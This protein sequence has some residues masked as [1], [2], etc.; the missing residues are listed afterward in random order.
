MNPAARS[1]CVITLVASA[2]GWARADATA[3]AGLAGLQAVQ[4]D[5]VG[6]SASAQSLNLLERLGD[7]RVCLPAIEPRLQL[8]AAWRTAG[9]EGGSAP[10]PNPFARR[11]VG[12]ADGVSTWAAGRVQHARPAGADPGSDYRLSTPG[13][14]IGMDGAV[15]TG[16]RLGVAMSRG[17]ERDA[18]G[19]DRVRTSSNGLAAY[20]SWPGSGSLR[21]GAAVGQGRA[22]A[23][24]LRGV[25]EGVAT[26]GKRR[27]RQ[28]FVAVSASARWASGRWQLAPQLAAEHRRI[29]FGG[30]AEAG[31]PQRAWSFDEAQL[32]T[33]E[34]RGAL[35]MTSEWS[36]PGCTLA[37]ALQLDWRKRSR[38]EMAQS[39]HAPDEVPADAELLTRSEPAQEETRFGL[40]LI[41]RMATGWRA[42]FE[43]RNTLGGTAPRSMQVAA[44][45]RRSF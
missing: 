11:G 15:G 19:N 14:S 7:E 25:G 1:L 32:E 3:D 42:S 39:L 4:A 9:A 31:D 8:A 34:L 20:A 26:Q 28:N 12:C 5:A 23:R 17:D 16:L 40:G 21:L 27:A 35:R 44:S 24:V 43:T 33:S 41:L 18:A 45:M 37:P 2:T 13:L 29:R 22:T 30:Y 36:L 10:G 38:S 6:R